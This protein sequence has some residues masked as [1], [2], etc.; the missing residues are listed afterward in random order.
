MRP[1]LLDLVVS[2][3][4]DAFSCGEL[5]FQGD[6]AE[7]EQIQESASGK[8]YNFRITQLNSLQ[9]RPE[10][11]SILANPF[12]KPE[13]GLTILS[14]YGSNDEFRLVLNKYPVVK[15]HFM[16]VTKAFK[17]QNSPLA[18]DELHST[19][20]ILH[21]LRSSDGHENWFAFYNCGPESGASQPHKH[22][23][24]MTLPQ[25]FTPF[26]SEIVTE[27][28]RSSEDE[29]IQPL[30]DPNMPFAHFIAKLSPDS[31]DNKDSIAMTFASLLQKTLN[32]LV[33]AKCN[34]IS[35]NL[36]MTTEYMMIVPRAAKKFKDLIGINSCGYMGLV[37]CKDPDTYKKVKEV[38]I[39][40]IL[41]ALALPP[42][43]VM[44]TN[45]YHY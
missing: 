17:S 21:D 15:Y 35:Y 32:V 6:S 45:E 24:F 31:I 1:P 29:S 36:C 19:L 33:E 5:V 20:R 4:D 26:C 44:T 40:N 27:A 9:N 37:L 38:G 39:L 7:Q 22:I 14:S 3:F 43:Y 16:L 25:D 34:H 28:G 42:H 11:G 41:S 8:S 23:Q 18:S 10:T 13:P 2:K 30:L 12:A